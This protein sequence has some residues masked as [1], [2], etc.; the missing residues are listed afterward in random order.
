MKKLFLTLATLACAYALSMAYE[1]AGSRIKTRWASEVT[2]QNVHQEYP[3]PQ[4]VREA[5]TNLN[6][7]W[8][9]AITDSAAVSMPQADGQILV[10]FCVE[11]SLS[12]VGRTVEPGQALWYR[13]DVTVP[14]D[15]NGRRVLLNFGAV[16]WKCELSVNGE[17][18]LTHTGGYT[19][20]SAD[21]TP[22]LKDGKAELVLKVTD[23]TDNDA[24]SV[25]HG[26]QCR[27]P[28]S[29]WYTPVTGIWQTV[30]ME[31][32]SDKAYIADYN[33][34][35]DIKEGTVT[36]TPVVEGAME[37]D[38]VKVEI[39]R[40]RIGYSAEKP[41][42]S[43]FRKGKA[44]VDAGSDAIVKIR[45][46]RLW[47]PDTPYLYGVKI[48]LI[49]DGKVIDKVQAYTAMRAVTEQKDAAGAKR[50]ALNGDILFQFGPLDQGWWPDG[51]YTA[52]TDEALR[53]D[54]V[55]TKELG[56]NM[57]RKHIKV[58]PARWYYYCDREGIMVWQDMPSIGAYKD[59]TDWG[60]G[61][62]EYGAGR[63]YYA[64]TDFAARNY[65]KEWGEI[66]AQQKKFQSIVMWV[67]FNE[68]W[69]QFDTKAAV[70]FTKAQDPTRPVNAASGGNWIKGAGEILDS[71]HYPYP[72]MR[73]LD[74][75]MVNVLG[76]YGGIGMPLEG[77][78]WADEKSWGYVQY[79]DASEVTD[80]YVDY[81]KMLENLVVSESCAAAVYTQTTDVEIEVNGFYTY[82]R[83]VLK[84]DPARVREANLKVIN[85]LGSNRIPVI[86]T[87][88]FHGNAFGKKVDLF[89]LQNGDIT[90]Q[91]TNFGARLISVYTKD[92]NG[93]Y[94]D[95]IVGYDDLARFVDNPGE[96][97]LGATVGPVCNRIG[98]AQMTVDGKKYNLS[99]N[100]GENILHG[101]FKGVDMVVWKVVKY[102]SKS[103]TLNYVAPDGQDG[104]PGNLDITLTY[105]LT[106]D[107]AV[108]ITYSAT[109]DAVTPVNLSNHAFFN[110][111]GQQGGTILDH[112]LTISASAITPVDETLIPTGEFMPVEGTPFDFLEAHAIGE[113]IAEDNQQ[114]KYGN[115]YDHNWVLD[116]Y[117]G[118]FRKVCELSEPQSGRVLEILTDQPGLQFYAGN[119]FDGSYCGKNPEKPI[120]YREAL[121]IESQKF[122]DSV[123]HPEFTDTILKPGETYTQHTQ[124]RFGTVAA[125]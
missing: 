104:F 70:D 6:G 61:A 59:R 1:P 28:H 30:W 22:Y 63:D 87:L 90:A 35:T 65:Y 124:Y 3:R 73:L 20:F 113:R 10:P 83:E 16:D 100:D 26:K 95:V 101:G 36:V 48:R 91:V 109:T 106:E 51:L 41:G 123:N 86:S 94:D 108:D 78:T 17:A 117:D 74:P 111:K 114:L 24:V 99:K 67:P 13:T 122:P 97:F 8:D 116:G 98:K 75:E 112:M 37:G 82:D 58:E 42:W 7:L 49:R 107:N 25:P 39:L 125:E 92:K 64:L 66:L 69:G 9:Y 102:D 29:I 118:S 11:S 45:K 12:G 34:V 23:P 52:P 32:V 81:A 33:V 71:H 110:L 93:V 105:A 80:C 77:H 18:V 43:L 21:I 85:A 96:R 89:T 84:M 60:Q 72:R 44:V 46:P 76:E 103:I 50:L 40:P 4:M 56:F 38:Q 62:D 53:F 19:A 55:K 68:A 31:A 5:W 119:F 47:T 2:P 57:I 15:W 88:G 54:I 79:K 14:S 121:A 27:N 120:G 115:G